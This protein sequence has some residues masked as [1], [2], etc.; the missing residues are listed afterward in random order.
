MSDLLNSNLRH[1]QQAKWYGSLVSR[2]PFCSG[3]YYQNLGGLYPRSRPL[4]LFLTILHLITP[5]HGD[6]FWSVS[7][8][9]MLH[10]LTPIAFIVLSF[11]ST[12]V[13]DGTDG[14]LVHSVFR[15]DH[16]WGAG[17]ILNRLYTGYV[18]DFILVHYYDKLCPILILRSA[19]IGEV[20]CSCSSVLSRRRSQ[21][22]W[23]TRTH[24]KTTE[25]MA[26]ASSVSNSHQTE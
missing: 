7:G 14:L 18:V 2:S 1:S 9:G 26:V 4:L 6:C 25:S 10:I 21:S 13:C 23:K 3:C 24:Q 5:K 20:L 8:S 15:P 22:R 12:A 11:W 16:R 19:S 17:N